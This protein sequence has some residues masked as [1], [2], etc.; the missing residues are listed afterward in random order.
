MSMQSNDVAPDFEADTQRGYWISRPLGS[1]VAISLLVRSVR[2][3]LG[4]V[5]SEG[6]S[7]LSVLTTILRPD[8][9]WHPVDTDD[10][11]R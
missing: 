6:C 3:T 2:S 7:L 1:P 5:R 8:D 4:A 11:Q 10:A 9:D